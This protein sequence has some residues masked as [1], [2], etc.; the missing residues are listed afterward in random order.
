MPELL[1]LARSVAD[2]ALPGEQV[3]AYLARSSETSVRVFDEKVEQFSTS[4]NEGIG[5]R[6]VVGSRQGFAWKGSLEGHSVAEALSAA[7]E[8]A[9]FASPDERTQIAVPDDVAPIELGLWREELAGVSADAKLE[10]AFEL[11][12]RIL[13]NDKRMKRVVRSDYADSLIETALVTSTG[14]SSSTRRTMCQ[15]S[16]YG[17]AEEGGEQQAGFGVTAGR[18]T[19]DLDV[20]SCA[21]DVATRAT[22]LLGATKPRSSRMTV[23]FDRR[24]TAAIVRI[25]AETLSG[26]EVAKGRSI[27]AHRL[28]ESVAPPDVHLVEDPTDELALGASPVD[29]EG[30]ATRRVEL[31]ADGTVNAFLHDTRSGRAAGTASTGSA[32]RGSYRTAP[33]VGSRAV[34]LMP[35]RQSHEEIL[36]E[37]GDGLFVQSVSGLHSGVNPVSG[38]FSV[39]AE[40]LMIRGGA[41]ADPVR[42]MTVASTLQRILRDVFAVGSDLEWLPGPSAG[43]TIAVRDVSVGGT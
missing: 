23:V 36:A 43:L 25:L 24:V 13:A 9:A 4:E 42:E 39:G 20:D 35:G 8:N 38:D 22:R 15:L 41:L 21:A 11:E 27:F 32:V 33:R 1:E 28:G 16:G 10:L 7:R 29:G 37:A 5:V 2:A 30:L 17:I 18:A 3:E 34:S 6:V 31:I 14:I 12:R 26:E 40:G 19:S